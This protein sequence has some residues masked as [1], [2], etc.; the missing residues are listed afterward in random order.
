M[1]GYYREKF[2]I[3][4]FWELKGRTIGLHWHLYTTLKLHFTFFFSFFAHR[5]NAVSNAQIR[6]ETYGTGCLGQTGINNHLS[7]PSNQRA[8]VGKQDLWHKNFQNFLLLKLC[9]FFRHPPI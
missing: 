3:N 2:H 5:I 9:E 7:N 8:S 4:H 6:G 1:Y